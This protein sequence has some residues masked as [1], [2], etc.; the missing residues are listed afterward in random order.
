MMDTNGKTYEEEEIEIE[1]QE[2]E[3]TE[4]LETE[5]QTLEKKVEELEN[6]YK[7][8]LADYQNL[9]KR[10]RDDRANWILTANKQLLQK[11]LPVL[12]TLILAQKHSDD[13]SL[14]VTAD[15]FLGVI[16][17]EG[18]TQIET[19]GKKFDPHVM[20]AIDT[21]AGKD[22][23]VVEEVTAG[24]LLHETLLRAAQVIVGN[25]EKEEKN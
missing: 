9:E 15:Q 20:E 12:D 11:L 14:K 13:T 3:Q 7:R 8:A 22:G 25:G 10:Q 24:Y 21:R 17:A 6:K 2:V 16:K 18:L 19:V 4:E 23:E 1:A 5:K